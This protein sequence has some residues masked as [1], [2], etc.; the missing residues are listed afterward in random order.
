MNVSRFTPFALLG[1]LAASAACTDLASSDIT[2]SGMSATMSITA[3]ETGTTTASVQLNVDDNPTAFVTLSAGDSLK[4]TTGSQSQELSETS[5]LLGDVSYAATFQGAAANGTTYTIALDRQTGQS[6]PSSTCTLPAPFALSAPLPDATWSRA[7]QD[8]T[9]S[10][11]PSSGPDAMSWTIAMQCASGIA[12]YSGTVSGDPGSF[13]IPKGMLAGTTGAGPD[14]TC[15]ATLTV[16]RTRPGELDP[17]FT[18]G[19][20]DAVQA[21]ALTFQSA[22]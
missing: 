15:T 10:Y 13:V 2:T 5:D 11:A 1:S 12:D 6:A 18:G 4:A 7:N 8:I 22:P 16:N 19:A 9:V 21:R 17:A 3:D 20:I 14:G